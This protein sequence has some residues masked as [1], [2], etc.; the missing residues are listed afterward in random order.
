MVLGMICSAKLKENTRAYLR[1]Q[2]KSPIKSPNMRPMRQADCL[3]EDL[4]SSVERLEN[5]VCQRASWIL[6]KT[7]K[8]IDTHLALWRVEGHEQATIRHLVTRQIM[9]SMNADQ[10]CREGN[11]SGESI[12]ILVELVDVSDEIPAMEEIAEVVIRGAGKIQNQIAQ[13]L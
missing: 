3:F 5:Q 11:P 12:L 2:W 6:D 1:G 7:W 8:L 13:V 9:A 4:Q 10:K